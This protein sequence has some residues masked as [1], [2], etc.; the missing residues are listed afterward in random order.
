M[1][2]KTAVTS[3]WER[4]TRPLVNPYRALLV[5]PRNREGEIRRNKNRNKHFNRM[6]DGHTFVQ[7]YNGEEKMFCNGD[8][9]ISTL[10]DRIK[11]WMEGNELEIKPKYEID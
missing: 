2:G 8:D 11:K 4:E 5:L 10:F 6:G 1:V 7:I 3:H 9:V